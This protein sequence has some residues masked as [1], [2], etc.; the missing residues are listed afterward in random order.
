MCAFFVH[1][2][3]RLEDCSLYRNMESYFIDK[4]S[5]TENYVG[6]CA[7]T[8]DGKKLNEFCLYVRLTTTIKRGFRCFI[9]ELL[10]QNVYFFLFFSTSP[11]ICV[12]WPTQPIKL[13]NA[14]WSFNF[15]VSI[16][17]YILYSIPFLYQ[18]KNLI[19]ITCIAWKKRLRISPEKIFSY[20]ILTMYSTVTIHLGHKNAT[21]EKKMYA[22]SR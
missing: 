9:S 19:H 12:E 8:N 15:D 13:I 17:I 10:L 16:I 2:R 14:V 18:K 4:R 1:S 20:T 11:F 22:C 7:H 21:R 6:L 5:Y 3:L